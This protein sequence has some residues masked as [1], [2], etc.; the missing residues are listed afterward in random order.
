MEVEALK[1]QIYRQRMELDILNEAADRT[2][3]SSYFYQEEAQRRPDKYATLRAEVK[4]IFTQNQ[5]RYGYPAFPELITM[6]RL[7][8]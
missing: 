6:D 4:T 7:E 5:S 1:K 2:P 3:K 8:K